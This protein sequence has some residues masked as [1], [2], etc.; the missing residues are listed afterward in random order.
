MARPKRGWYPGAVFHV[1]ARGVQKKSIFCSE[2]DQ[3]MFKKILA[4]A[5]EKIHFEIVCY[6]LMSNHFHLVIKTDEIEIGKIMHQ[7]MNA[8]AKYYNKKYDLTGHVF[9]GRYVSKLVNNDRYLLEVSRYIHLNPVKAGIVRRPLDYPFSSY[10]D[11]VTDEKDPLVTKDM[12]ARM[13]CV[14]SYISEEELKTDYRKFVEG[15]A[16]HK[17]ME[18]QIQMDIKEDDDWLPR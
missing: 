11:Y 17:D 5:K 3:V 15:K 18:D 7:V 12:I 9:E 16:S 2:D 4:N 8:Y 1:M 10:K 14:E 6:C 13:F